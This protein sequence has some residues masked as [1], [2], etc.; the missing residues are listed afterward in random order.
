MGDS[1]PNAF[2]DDKV[3]CA[4]HHGEN[5]PGLWMMSWH[6][7]LLTESKVW[8]SLWDLPCREHVVIVQD[9][10]LFSVL[11]SLSLS[12]QGCN[13][14]MSDEAAY[15]HLWPTRAGTATSSSPNQDLRLTLWTHGDL[16][17]N[18]KQPVA[19]SFVCQNVPHAARSQ[20]YIPT[21]G[22]P[23]KSRACLGSKSWQ[24]LDCIFTAQPS[25]A[26]RR[27]AALF[28]H[29]IAQSIC[30]VAWRNWFDRALRRTGSIRSQKLRLCWE[31][32]W[33]SD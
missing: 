10:A 33:E 24:Q 27:A 2:G 23:L 5:F 32:P 29:K 18:R 20:D 13:H 30:S 25:P 28:Q 19:M 4:E 12:V 15:P 16:Q 7:Y 14:N 17:I 6:L 8:D 21:H 22:L 1:A 31:K 11:S 26:R 9:G 3:P